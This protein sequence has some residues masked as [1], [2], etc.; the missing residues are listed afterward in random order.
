MRRMNL[1][2]RFDVPEQARRNSRG[3]TR[4][5][6]RFDLSLG[7]VNE[8]QRIAP[9]RGAKPLEELIARFGGQVPGLGGAQAPQGGAQAPQGGA[10]VPDRRHRGP[11]RRAVLGVPACVAQAGN[12]VVKL[13]A[14]QDKVGR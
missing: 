5:D 4:G 14:C 6:M 13:Q 2:L 10:Q 1:A 11:R 9:P 3:L 7:A 8:D 12:D